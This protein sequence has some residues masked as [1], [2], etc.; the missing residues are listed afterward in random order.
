MCMYLAAEEG[1]VSTEKP[2][3]MYWK[4]ICIDLS[5]IWNFISKLCGYFSCG[6]DFW[7]PETRYAYTATTVPNF[8]VSYTYV[9]M[10]MVLNEVCV[11]S[12]I[13]C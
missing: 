2:D 9:K 3:Q 6:T 7:V 10:E 13:K 11:E 5:E 4:E 8:I 12:G 1:L